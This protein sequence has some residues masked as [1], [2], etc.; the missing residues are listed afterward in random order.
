MYILYWNFCNLSN[1]RGKNFS[2]LAVME[3]K[4]KRVNFQLIWEV[5]FFEKFPAGWNFYWKEEKMK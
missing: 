1:F 4:K 2:S 5:L 3:R